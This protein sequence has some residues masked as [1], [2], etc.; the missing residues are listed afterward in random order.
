V[1]GQV[2]EAEMCEDEVV[3]PVTENEI[4]VEK[5][6]VAKD[7]VRIRKDVVEDTEGEEDVRSAEIEVED[8]TERRNTQAL[9]SRRLWLVRRMAILRISPTRSSPKY[10]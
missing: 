3:A 1:K 6:P 5:H 7:E 9:P 8:D 4:V 2:S 10:E